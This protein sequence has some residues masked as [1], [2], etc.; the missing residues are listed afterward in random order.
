MEA[1]VREMRGRVAGSAVA[2]PVF[3]G[4]LPVEEDPQSLQFDFTKPVGLVMEPESAILRCRIAF[5]EVQFAAFVERVDPRQQ[6]V[7]VV[8]VRFAFARADG[9]AVDRQESV[10]RR[11]DV[12]FRRELQVLEVV[13]DQ[14]GHTGQ[15]RVTG[16]FRHVQAQCRRDPVL[17]GQ[18]LPGCR[19][20]GE[21]FGVGE[22]AELFCQGARPVVFS[23]DFAGM[24]CGQVALAGQPA[25][26]AP[27]ERGNDDFP[28]RGKLPVGM[29]EEGVP[30]C[31]GTHQHR[32]IPYGH[33][34]PVIPFR[35]GASGGKVVVGPHAEFWLPDMLVHQVAGPA[36]VGRS[37]ERAPRKRD[38]VGRQPEEPVGFFQFRVP[39]V[40]RFVDVAAAGHEIMKTLG[41]TGLKEQPLSMED[42]G[43]VG[44]GDFA[45]LHKTAKACG[46]CCSEKNDA[47][48]HGRR[49][50]VR[51][52]RPVAGLPGNPDFPW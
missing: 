51:V 5:H 24:A 23:D 18:R 29:Q 36:V 10:V 25:Q 22:S 35:Q 30:G 7:A 21:H 33:G 48:V 6:P 3:G 26:V 11:K 41:E 16:D 46:G 44:C 40:K 32:R 9:Q 34:L 31:Q 28:G 13:F 1:E 27:R 14:A 4:R 52:R 45:S 2:S 17:F 42:F 12:G 38:L 43:G 19:E 37:L 50:P 39:C 47:Q 20:A 15:D 8:L 49:G